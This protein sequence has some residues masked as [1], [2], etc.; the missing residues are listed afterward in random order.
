MITD[1]TPANMSSN[2]N[3]GDGHIDWVASHQTYE[4][5][6][7]EQGADHQAVAPKGEKKVKKTKKRAVSL[8]C[9]LLLLGILI[10]MQ[11]QPGAGEPVKKKQKKQK[12]EEKKVEE[13]KAPERRH[14]V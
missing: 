4:E 5:F 13:E 6:V 3:W 1:R 2:K 14:S 7:A 12:K 11:A 9:C 8:P 10:A